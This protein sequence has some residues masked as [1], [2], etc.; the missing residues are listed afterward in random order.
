M[1]PSTMEPGDFRL[2]S[3]LLN[4]NIIHHAG[5]DNMQTAGPQASRHG[6][7]MRRETSGPLQTG[8][9]PLADAEHVGS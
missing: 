5:T 4:S 2:E 8:H 7:H 6:P 3:S 1:T 9:V